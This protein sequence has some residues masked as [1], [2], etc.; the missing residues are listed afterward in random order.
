MFLV[1]V[2]GIAACADAPARLDAGPG[3]VGP[4]VSAAEDASRW[5]LDMRL[6]LEI[7]RILDLRGRAER[8][9]AAARSRLGPAL[10]AYEALLWRE[11]R[12][13]RERLATME[14]AAAG[15]S[16]PDG[17]PIAD[18]RAMAARLEKLRQRVAW[19]DEARRA[20][21]EIA[22]A[23][24]NSDRRFERERAR[25]LAEMAIL[26]RLIAASGARPES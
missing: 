2:S 3:E 14:L 18:A 19:R 20:E 26:R 7:E 6:D 13:E 25:T 23:S 21:A 15:I 24:A 8:G 10:D 9:D 5:P 22:R 12:E 1:A 16:A 17:G 11:R 4:S